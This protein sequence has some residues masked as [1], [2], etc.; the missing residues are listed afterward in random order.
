[1]KL[2]IELD[3]N[4]IDYDVIN[5]QIAEKVAALNIKETYEIES[6]IDKK[7]NNYI[8]DEV[9]RCY[10]SYLEKYW[11]EPS[12]IG[13]KMVDSMT[14]TELETRVTKVLDDIFTNTYNDDTLKEIMVKILPDVFTAILFNKL[15]SSLLTQNYNYQE[16]MRTIIRND[17][18]D[19]LSR[20][21]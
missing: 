12:S 21:Y 9:D 19:R 18:E 11:G 2:E 13:S 7:I 4:K 15:E 8:T 10:N 3:L 17:I 1:M 16:M 14:K 6:K 20:N 5:K